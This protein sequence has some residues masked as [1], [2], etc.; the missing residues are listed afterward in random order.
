MLPGALLVLLS[1]SSFCYLSFNLIFEYVKKKKK[2]SRLLD[3][4]TNLPYKIYVL[5][6][7]VRLVFKL[8]TSSALY[9]IRAVF[10]MWLH[11][12]TEKILF[13]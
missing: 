6:Y 8:L 12:I 9:T 11:F 10:H 4:V 3:A 5:H 7:A 1:N 13:R 2:K